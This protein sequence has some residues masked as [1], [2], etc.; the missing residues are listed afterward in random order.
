MGSQQRLSLRTETLGITSYFLRHRGQSLGLLPM[1]ELS[2]LH[3]SPAQEIPPPF[4]AE[5]HNALPAQTTPWHWVVDTCFSCHHNSC[6][7]SVS[8]A[9]LPAKHF[10]VAEANI[11]LHPRSCLINIPCFLLISFSVQL[12]Q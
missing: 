7:F 6:L 10:E 12:S 5:Q 2:C 1:Q 4:S 9:G 8:A 3:L 11:Q